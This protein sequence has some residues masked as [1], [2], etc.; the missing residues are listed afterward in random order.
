MVH[1]EPGAHLDHRHGGS[2]EAWLAVCARHA[3]IP[4][5]AEIETPAPLR[6]ATP[7]ARPQ[8]ILRRER[9]RLLA[10]PRRLN[11]LMVGLRA[12]RQRAGSPVCGGARTTGGTGTTRGPVTP[13]A[14]DG[15][16]AMRV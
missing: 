2:I 4:Y 14:D 6:Q 5:P 7:H 1:P 9:R 13:E 16:P 11:R 12:N 3:K 15:T 8:R 10:L